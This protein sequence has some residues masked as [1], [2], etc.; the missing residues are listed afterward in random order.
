MA[1]DYKQQETILK[2]INDLQHKLNENVKDN[3]TFT[4]RISGG[5]N[6]Q[7]KIYNQII[8]AGKDAIKNGKQVHGQVI[9][10]IQLMGRL[11]KQ[12]L[13][14]KDLEKEKNILLKESLELKAAGLEALAAEAQKDADMIDSKQGQIRTGKVI[15]AQHA[16]AGTLLGINFDRMNEL[17]TMAMEYGKDVA[18]QVL[19]LELSVKL[20]VDFLVS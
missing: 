17:E 16:A 7:L 18:A 5:L 1:T 9:R 15:N 8:D 10:D 19:A 11:S 14:I 6:K 3:F 20:Y 4:E 13:S 12:N 2:S